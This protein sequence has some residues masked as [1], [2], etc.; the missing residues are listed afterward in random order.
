MQLIK[1]KD[2]CFGCSICAIKCPQQAIRMRSD[3]MGFIY[4]DIDESKCIDCGL[5]SN[6]C[7]INSTHDK[8]AITVKKVYACRLI[9]R[10]ELTKSQSGGAFWALA[11]N[12]IERGGVVYG[13]AFLNDFSVVHIRTTTL[14]EMEKLRGSKYVQSDIQYTLDSIKADLKSKLTVLFTGTPCQIAGLRKFI[15]PAESENLYT[16]DLI[17]HGVPAPFVWKDYVKWISKRHE[18]I[19]TDCLFRDKSFGW[20]SHIE[21]FKFTNGTKISKHL[22][23]DLFYNHFI[24]RESC[25]NCPYTNL[26]R[27]S[28]IT[29]GDYWGWEKV[30]SQFNDQRGVSLVLINTNKGQNLFEKAKEFLEYEK[31]NIKDCMQ[32]QL[33]EPA[34]RPV[35]KNQFVDDYTSRGFD[36][37]IHKYGFIGWKYEL[38][39][40]IK[41]ITTIFCKIKWHIKHI[42][43]S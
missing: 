1:N 3:S 24:I 30:S 29:I 17:C 22:F 27:G 15:G 16:I 33:Q 26:N 40:V 9:D 12:I 11:K 18:G 7:T 31:S 34:H 36:Y 2:N 5:C 25:H 38:N 19:I 10:K 42:S 28:D 21:T 41:G 37:V 39:V 13:A 20:G 6:I 35:D 8:S 32:P 23:R 43:K 4:P 14:E